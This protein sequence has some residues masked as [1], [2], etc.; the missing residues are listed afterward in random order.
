MILNHRKTIKSVISLLGV[1]VQLALMRMRI[2][3]PCTIFHGPFYHHRLF[4][5]TTT[6]SLDPIQ[7]VCIIENTLTC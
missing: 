7:T 4:M 3:C 1:L 2:V 6:V 5:R